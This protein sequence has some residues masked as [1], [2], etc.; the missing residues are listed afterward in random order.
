MPFFGIINK[1]YE[2]IFILFMPGSACTLQC[3]SAYSLV[4]YSLLELG[5]ELGLELWLQLGLKLELEL[6]LELELELGLKL[7]LELGLELGL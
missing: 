1:T 7:G 3:E 4:H 2:L 6:G 5:L